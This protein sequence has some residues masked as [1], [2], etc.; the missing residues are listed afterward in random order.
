ML[1]RQSRESLGERTGLLVREIGGEREV[2]VVDEV[3][4]RPA[5]SRRKRRRRTFSEI[6]SSQARGDWGLVPAAPRG[7]VDERGLRHVLRVVRIAELAQGRPIDIGAMPPI[8]LFEC[9][10][11]GGSS[12]AGSTRGHRQHNGRSAGKDAGQRSA[13]CFAAWSQRRRIRPLKGLTTSQ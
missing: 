5:L 12:G 6:A 8:E 1:R 10:I 7:G 3:L 2:G 9:E 13:R 4:A 11:Y